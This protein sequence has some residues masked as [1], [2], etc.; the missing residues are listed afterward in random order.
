MSIIQKLMQMV[1]E[2]EIRKSAKSDVMEMAL[3]NHNSTKSIHKAD[4]IR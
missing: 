3:H 2:K 4:K 1:N